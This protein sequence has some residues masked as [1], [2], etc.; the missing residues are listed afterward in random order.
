MRRGPL[1]PPERHPFK[2]RQNS[3]GNPDE[4]TERDSS[5]GALAEVVA[6]TAWDAYE[7]SHG[8]RSSKPEK[9][10][11]RYETKGDDR[12]VDSG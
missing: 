9:G 10:S 8:N 4:E 6:R 3:E 2:Y 1:G 7:H 11:Y 5:L 12:H